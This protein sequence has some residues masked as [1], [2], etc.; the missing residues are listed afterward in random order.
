MSVVADLQHQVVQG[1]EL[2]GLVDGFGA[3][4]WRSEWRL[5]I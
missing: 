4:S 1:F 3:C 5:P 2:R